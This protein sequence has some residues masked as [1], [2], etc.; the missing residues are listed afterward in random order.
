MAISTIKNELKVITQDVT[1][2]HGGYN[3]WSPSVNAS[4]I[5]HIQNANYR[6]KAVGLNGQ[7]VKIN[8]IKSGQSDEWEIVPTT[9]S[10]LTVPC[11]VLVGGVNKRLSKQCLGAPHECI[12][13][14][15]T[16]NKCFDGNPIV[17]D[18]RWKVLL[19][20]R[21]V[22]RL[23]NFHNNNEEPSRESYGTRLLHVEFYQ[24]GILFSFR[25]ND[26]FKRTINSRQQLGRMGRDRV[27]HANSNRKV[28]SKLT[29]TLRE[30][31]AA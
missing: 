2:T 25:C 1:F 29:T 19:C 10:P 16:Y 20:K 17:S 21:D 15:K 28:D 18:R 26:I 12:K 31:V 13:D 9:N 11:A 5:I 23:S 3:L 8:V 27:F 22:R 24:Q 6:L 14:R 30:E 7:W 4:R